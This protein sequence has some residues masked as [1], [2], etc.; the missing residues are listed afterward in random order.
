MRVQIDH[1]Q[2]GPSTAPQALRPVQG[3]HQCPE[4]RDRLQ[5]AYAL[6]EDYDSAP[7][8]ALPF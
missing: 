4:A 1:M 5:D 7:N 3:L 2:G 8:T 6:P